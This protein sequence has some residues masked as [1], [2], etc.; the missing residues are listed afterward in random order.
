MYYS[1]EFT[2]FARLCGGDLQ[3]V[4]HTERDSDPISQVFII[5]AEITNEIDAIKVKEKNL[6]QLNEEI[7]TGTK[8]PLVSVEVKPDEETLKRRAEREAK[9]KE[10]QEKTKK[11]AL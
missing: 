5:L 3:F 2:N 10:E 7:G 8:G 11:E 6:A 1:K 9:E 4:T